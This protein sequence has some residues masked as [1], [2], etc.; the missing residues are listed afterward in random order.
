MIDTAE[1]ES[2]EMLDHED[3]KDYLM[4]ENIYKKFH[5]YIFILHNVHG[6]IYE[7]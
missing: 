7:L 2:F 5:I 3:I 4:I 6:D 1:E